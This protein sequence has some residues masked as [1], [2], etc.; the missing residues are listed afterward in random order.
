MAVKVQTNDANFPTKDA[1]LSESRILRRL[2]DTNQRHEGYSVVRTLL[3]CFEVPGPHG[4]HICMVH[5]PMREPISIFRHHFQGKHFDPD[6]LRSI[7]KILLQGLD[8]QHRQCHV[9]HTGQSA[10]GLETITLMSSEDLNPNNILV[11]FEQPYPLDK[12]VQGE[13]D[14]PSEQKPPDAQ[15]RIIYRSRNQFGPIIEGS[16]I[17]RPLIADYGHAVQGDRLRSDPHYNILIQPELLRAPEVI[18]RAGW[19][20]S[21]D[22]WNFGVLVGGTRSLMAGNIA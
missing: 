6:L 17:G 8:Y 10:P 7:V 9:I 4:S 18:F 22:I 14:L 19:T 16:V 20:Y 3:D 13:V 5:E 12:F 1:A 11:R 2:T 15:G 21:A